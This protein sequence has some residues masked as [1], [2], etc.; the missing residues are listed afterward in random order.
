MQR[1]STLHLDRV[2]QYDF[3]HTIVETSYAHC[4][5]YSVSRRGFAGTIEIA[6][7]GEGEMT[8][9]SSDAVR[10][11]RTEQHIRRSGTDAFFISA[12]L[13]G[14]GHFR[15]NDRTVEHAPG[16]IL[17]YDSARP[18]AYDYPGAYRTM[19]L[20]VPRPM[21]AARMLGLRDL[22]GTVLSPERPQAA[23]IRGLMGNLME[24]ARGEDLPAHFIAP[25]LDLI[26]GAFG[27][28]RGD[29]RVMAAGRD[30]TLN[31]IKRF[32]IAHMGNEEL[33]GADICA[34]QNVSLRSL[35]RL[36]AAEGTTPMAWLRDSRLAEA[37]AMLSEGRA[38][39][40]TEAAYR[41]GFRDLSYFGRA[42][43]KAYG[44]TPRQIGVLRRQ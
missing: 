23:L 24:T 21:M 27:L 8:A 25:A 30:E 44:R 17:I 5:G 16:T 31:R 3:W 39:S 4:D 33:S 34:A 9:L 40:V 36:F 37:H 15:Q 32:M 7:C 6:S 10:Y 2:Q 26:T 35:G 29:G 18:Y 19:L 13:E 1:L 41:C 43:K 28:G 14:G 11:R 42:F 12:M 22:G 38:R 20:R